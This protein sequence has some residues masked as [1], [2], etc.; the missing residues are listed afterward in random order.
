MLA[1]LGALTGGSAACVPVNDLDEYT[2]A[3]AGAGGAPLPGGPAAAGSA[4]SSMGIPPDDP[5]APSAGG[6]S[7]G[8][9]SSSGSTAGSGSGGSGAAGDGPS[10]TPSSDAGDPSP[11]PDGA[12]PRP[13]PACGEGELEGPD[14]SCFFLDARTQ[15]FFAARSACQGRGS[16]WDLA[17][18]R[19]AE[20]S[21]FLGNA[22][23]FEG[24][25]LASDVASEGNWIWLDDGA[26]FWQGGTNGAPSSG[27][28]TNWNATEPNGGNTTN[29]MRALPR[30]AGSANPDAPWADIACAELRGGICQGPLQ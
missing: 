17:S 12:P 20:V 30:S 18:V 1:A 16:G 29:C 22:L 15:T 14:E 2:P 6:G 9:G 28:Y 4:G 5:G 13:A 21:A 24:W 26:P 7:S 11:T 3:S 10:P 27:A 19:S 23:T 25:L 8:G